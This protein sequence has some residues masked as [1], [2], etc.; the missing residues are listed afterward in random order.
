MTKSS[1]IGIACTGLIIMAI[2]E[3]IFLLHIWERAHTWPSAATVA[4]NSYY[5]SL[6]LPVLWH[7]PD[8]SFQDQNGNWTS[9]RSLC[10]HIWISDFFFTS[11]T[12]ICPMMTAKMAHLQ[13][14]L[15]DTDIRFV[16]FSV[17]PD[18]DTPA[19]L[20]QYAAMWKADE[21]R[22]RFLSTDR[23]HLVATA[24]GMRTF[25]QPPSKDSP[26]QHSS[27]FILTDQNGDVRGVYD[28]DDNEAL[29]RLVQD[30]AGLAG[31]RISVSAMEGPGTESTDATNVSPLSEDPGAALYAA[32]GC[33]GCH[34]QGRVA[35]PLEGCFGREVLLQDGRKVIADEAY[36]RESILDPAK[37][38]VEGYPALM[39]AYRGQLS[40][41]ELDQLVGYL[42][43]RGPTR[44][45][46]KSMITSMQMIDPVC[47]MA[48]GINSKAFETNFSGKT[49]RF[50]SVVCRDRFLKA[51]EQ[52]IK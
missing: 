24:E 9:S 11:C 49:Y 4:Y 32:R 22:W 10:G 50:C 51:P 2:L 25:V 18:H 13:R 33:L 48:V 37:K 3:G 30:V 23:Q 52:F 8:F 21:M 39:P 26:I 5:R 41:A 7:A 20:K 12:S 14:A 28:S 1:R 40:D 44:S 47:K 43:A 6:H 27:L 36:L 35:P 42:M 45:E 34:T 46:Q 16:S 17:D 19:V 31:H 38:V 15:T 29:G